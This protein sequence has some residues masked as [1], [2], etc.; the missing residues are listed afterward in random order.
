MERLFVYGSPMKYHPLSWVFPHWEENPPDVM[1]DVLSRKGLAL[2]TSFSFC[3][4]CAL[5]FFSIVLQKGLMTFCMKDLERVLGLARSTGDRVIIVDTQESPIVV[6]PLSEYERVIGY[7]Q[8]VQSLTEEELLDKINRDIAVWKQ[9]QEEV[10]WDD[11]EPVMPSDSPDRDD[12][13]VYLEP[14]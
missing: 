3:K 8:D 10:G 1:L 7:R 12:D 2:L 6:M 14:V 4:A 13:R 9:S 5:W 11:F